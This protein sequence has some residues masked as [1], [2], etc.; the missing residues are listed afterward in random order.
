MK[1]TTDLALRIL[2][3]RN[4]LRGGKVKT[5]RIVDVRGVL[6][7][8][9]QESLVRSMC[10]LLEAEEFDA[11]AG[12]ELA[13]ALLANAM[14]A[15]WRAHGRLVESLAVRNRRKDYDEARAVE[16]PKLPHG[17]RVLIVDDLVR[18][19][20]TLAHAQQSLTE[21]GYDVVCTATVVQSQKATSDTTHLLEY[22]EHVEYVYAAHAPLEHPTSIFAAGRMV[23]AGWA[24][25]DFAV[26]V[27]VPDEIGL[28]DYR[29]VLPGQ[30][31]ALSWVELDREKHVRRSAKCRLGP[32]QVGSRVFF[33]AGRI[34]SLDVDTRAVAD[35]DL[36][37]KH[38]GAHWSHVPQNPVVLDFG[39]QQQYLCYVVEQGMAWGESTHGTLMFRS[40]PDLVEHSRVSFGSI[41]TT[42]PIKFG[43]SGVVIGTNSGAVLQITPGQR[44]DEIANIGSPVKK[45]ELLHDRWLLCLGLDRNLSVRHIA[46]RSGNKPRTICQNVIGFGVHYRHDKAIIGCCNEQSLTFMDDMGTISAMIV[47]D[48][49]VVGMQTL[50]AGWLLLTESGTLVVVALEGLVVTKYRLGIDGCLGLHTDGHRSV[51]RARSETLV[52]TIKEA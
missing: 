8:V 33:N 20:S 51:I 49:T 37:L 12:P 4:V 19:G 27:D 25:G 41:S 11:V 44:V 50:N 3:S 38:R 5:D 10:D 30:Q 14:A 40:L 52:V 48:D 21:A 35:L 28:V 15:H 16:G 43:H 42:P 23:D 47:L 7:S 22:D 32:V 6:G 36:A 34:M 18:S 24:V 26:L 17:S 45:L 2:V 29:N 39:Q 46:G 9:H 13:G 31:P 1:D